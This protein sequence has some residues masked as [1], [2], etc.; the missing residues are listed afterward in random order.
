MAPMIL[1]REAMSRA[2]PLAMLEG[3]Q[4]VVSLA[5]LSKGFVE[6]SLG[7]RERAIVMHRVDGLLRFAREGEESPISHLS[8]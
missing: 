8:I 5:S 6:S 2:R 7:R 1:E 4:P 3:D